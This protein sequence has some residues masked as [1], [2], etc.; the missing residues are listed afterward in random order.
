[1]LTAT[2]I[3]IA[4]APEDYAMG[5]VQRILYVHVSVAWLSLLGFLAM[6]TLA[7]LHL[8]TRD[9]L[10]DMWARAANE[11]GWVCCSLT[12]LTGSVWARAAWG[13]WWTWEPRLTTTFVLWLLYSGS[14]LL[15]YQSESPD[16]CA[17]VCSILALLGTLD[18]PLIVMATRW[19]RGIHPVSPEMEPAMRVTL[20][21]SI[22]CFTVMFLVVLV[23]R[24]NRLVMTY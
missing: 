12:L 7:L 16:R 8:T 19:F 5:N 24:K 6:A 21:L 23:A 18:V 20:A 14:L 2:T 1:M 3:A 4:L 22:A 13:T 11:L 15:R 9:L 10:W 17:R